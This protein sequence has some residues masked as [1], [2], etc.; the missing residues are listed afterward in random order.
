MISASTI[1]PQ[2]AQRATWREPIMRGLRAP[3][4]EMR[5]APAG[6]PG[7]RSG[8]CRR[9]CQDAVRRLRPIAVV[10]LISALTILAVVAHLF[11]GTIPVSAKI[12]LAP[13][14]RGLPERTRRLPTRL[15]AMRTAQPSSGG[16]TG[17]PATMRWQD[18]SYA[19]GG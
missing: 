4:D 11:R 19:P 6:A 16:S 13:S 18:A 17:W 5:R 10:V 12:H 9:R 14:C 15:R 3:S 1:V 7:S 8:V 2:R